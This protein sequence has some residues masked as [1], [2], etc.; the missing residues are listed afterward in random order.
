MEAAARPETLVLSASTTVPETGAVMIDKTDGN[1]AVLRILLTSDVPYSG[2]LTFS[3]S[4]GDVTVEVK[5]SDIRAEVYMDTSDVPNIKTAPLLTRGEGNVNFTGGDPFKILQALPDEITITTSQTEPVALDGE[6][7]KKTIPY[8]ITLQNPDADEDYIF[9]LEWPEGLSRPEGLLTLTGPDESG[10]YGITCGQ[11]VVELVTLSLPTGVSIKENSL[12]ANSSGLTFTLTAS[13]EEEGSIENP[14]TVAVTVN[15]DTF[16]RTPEFTSGAVTL[17]TTNSEGKPISASVEVTAEQSGLPGD[18]DG[19]DVVVV[20]ETSIDQTVGWADGNNE[21][22]KQPNGWSLDPENTVGALVPTLYFTIDGVTYPLTE[23]NLPRV[24][25]TG[26]PVI[27]ENPSQIVIPNLPSK[28]QEQ[29]AYGVEAT[30]DVT[31]S[32]EPPAVPDG[33]AFVE[34]TEENK[35]N[36]PSVNGTLG[37]T[38]SRTSLPSVWKPRWVLTAACQATRSVLF[39]ETSSSSGAMVQTEPENAASKI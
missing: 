9:T 3:A 11:N 29:S 2:T 31:W 34:V 5:K 6:D 20:E 12:T 28:I 19:F 14:Y 35:N 1:G 23:E 16:T 25:L 33:Y 30:Y 13:A 37:C 39:C 26:W 36:Y 4:G 27:T 32:L 22:G 8:T 24:G 17:S 38:C 18:A 7:G 10:Q 15:A 21:A